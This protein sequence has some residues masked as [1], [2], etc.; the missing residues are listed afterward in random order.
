MVARDLVGYGATRQIPAWP[1]GA[2]IAVNFNLMSRGG[3]ESTARQ[4]RRR[5]RGHAQRHRR[6]Y[7]AR[8]PRTPLVESVFEYR[9]RRGAWRVLDVFRRFLDQDEHPRR[10][11]G[12]EQ[13]P[14][15]AKA[16][17]ARRPRDGRPR[18]PLG[19]TT[20]RSPQTSNASTSIARST[21]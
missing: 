21:F 1:D 4:R 9:S 19:S 15:L 12:L 3:G 17:V 11:R 20:A 18:L 13:N 16:C 2:L 5:L 10:R 6:R 14:E 8:R 7:A